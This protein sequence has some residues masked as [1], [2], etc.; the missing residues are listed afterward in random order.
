MEGAT[1]DQI[2]QFKTAAKETAADMLARTAGVA[3]DEHV[4]MPVAQFQFLARMLATL[5]EHIGNGDAQS[6]SQS[7]CWVPLEEYQRMK[8][9][10]ETNLLLNSE[11]LN[12]RG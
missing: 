11:R 2:E 10:L 8:Q 5:S 7:K 1:M 4:R 3:T 6:F 9:R 12:F